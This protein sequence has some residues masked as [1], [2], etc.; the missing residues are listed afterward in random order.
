MGAAAV[1]G[2]AAEV[3]VAGCVAALAVLANR[4]AAGAGATGCAAGVARTAR[5]AAV[6]AGA[7]ISPGATT[8]AVVL[9]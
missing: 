3:V 1:D 5:F 6:V 7:A 8:A 2:I 9:A 4:F